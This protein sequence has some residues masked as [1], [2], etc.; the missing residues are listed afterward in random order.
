MRGDILA[1]YGTSWIDK[2]IQ[3]VTGQKVSH[4]AIMTGDELFIEAIGKGVV[5]SKLADKNSY[6]LLRDESLTK[7]QKRKIIQFTVNKLNKEYDFKLFVSVGLNRL[8]GI[9]LPW[10]DPNKYICIEL[11]SKA[12]RRVGI[13]LFPGIKDTEITPGDVMNCK[14]LKVVGHEE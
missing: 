3:F 11:I 12:Y 1:C 13:E 5:V 6:Y 9:K 4:T 2:L 10:N 8:F 14:R 7:E